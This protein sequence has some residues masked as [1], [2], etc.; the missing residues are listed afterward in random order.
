[1]KY[2]N[3]GKYKKLSTFWNLVQENTMDGTVLAGLVTSIIRSTIAW[4]RCMKV[5]Y[6]IVMKQSRRYHEVIHMSVYVCQFKKWKDE[7]EISYFIFI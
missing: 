3:Q 1:M 5:R 2:N 6:D 4:W 7:R